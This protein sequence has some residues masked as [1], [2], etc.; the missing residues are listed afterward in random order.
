MEHKM[1][2]EAIRDLFEMLIAKYEECAGGWA[3]ES[4][5]NLV[6]NESKLEREIADFRRQL[7]DLLTH[8]ANEDES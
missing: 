1:N 7:D 5:G 2:I 4:T 6:I 3:Y 8:V